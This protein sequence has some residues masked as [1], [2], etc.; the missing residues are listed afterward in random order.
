[1]AKKSRF[2]GFEGHRLCC[3][4]TSYDEGKC[5]VIF[6][7]RRSEWICLS[8]TKYQATHKH[9]GKLCDL[10]FAWEKST[11]RCT[12]AALELKGGGIS[13]SGAVKQ[14]QEGAGMIDKLLS[15]T[16]LV[17]VPVL[18]HRGLTAIQINQLRRQKIRF[19]GKTFEIELMRCGQK[20]ADLKL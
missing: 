3:A 20:L 18:V 6:P 12:C 14:L 8:G 15:D 9:E 17:F 16:E 2:D 4:I 19:R 5:K 13:V 10:L 1:V 7:N 11:S